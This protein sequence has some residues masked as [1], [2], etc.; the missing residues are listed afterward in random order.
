MH[1]NLPSVERLSVHIENG[2]SIM[3]DPV[4]E[5]AEE[6]LSRSDLQTT[7][8]TAFFEACIR[9]PDITVGLL[10][11][12]CPTKFVWKT[13]ERRWEPRQQGYT[14]GRAFFCAPSAGEQY[15]LRKLLY[16][17]PAP[18]SWE[19][20]RTVDSIRYSTFQEACAARGLLGPD[21]EWHRCLDE[22]GLI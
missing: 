5:A 11:P 12:D 19:F 16:T 17:V 6:V 10:Y 7:K 21:D 14:I 18:T 8:L 2:D 22:A 4:I 15:Y 9:F 1:R 13:K 20:L 3:Y